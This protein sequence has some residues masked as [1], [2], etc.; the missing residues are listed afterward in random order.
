MNIYACKV[1]R[2]ICRIMMFGIQ[3]VNQF[4]LA[5]H[6]CF[7]LFP[8]FLVIFTKRQM[9]TCNIFDTKASYYY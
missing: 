9:I 7:F 6:L 3:E 1:N 8:R 2:V 5:L 4:K